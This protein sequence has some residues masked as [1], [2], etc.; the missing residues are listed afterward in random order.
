[1]AP[2]SCGFRRRGN[3][4]AARSRSRMGRQ[5]MPA[6][7]RAQLEEGWAIGLVGVRE[8]LGP[9]AQC[10]LRAAGPVFVCSADEGGEQRMRLKRFG[11]EFRME[12]ASQEPGMIRY[13]ADLHVHRIGGLSGDAQTARGQNFFVLAVELV[14]MPVPLANLGHAVG[15][16]RKTA[17][18][19]L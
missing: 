14:T 16:A 13:F 1:M 19:Q 17:F 2:R 3:G 9:R 8:L 7:I 18:G 15:F 12:L 11:F 5:S 6:A 10:R 4:R